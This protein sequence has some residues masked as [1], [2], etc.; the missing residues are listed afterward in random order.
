MATASPVARYALRELL[1]VF[2]PLTPL[3]PYRDA[4]LNVWRTLG[5]YSAKSV[6][7]KAFVLEVS[8]REYAAAVFA[9]AQHL[10]NQVLE[11]R[12]QLF[13]AIA[14]DTEPS[15]T[16]LAVTLYYMGLYAAMSWTRVTNVA[17]VYL[18]REA[19]AQLCG[20]STGHPGAGAFTMTLKVPA[21][22]HQR[23]ELHVSKS[24]SHFHEAVWLHST[25]EARAAL[26]WVSKAAQSRNASSDEFLTIRA[27]SSICNP[28]FDGRPTWPSRL[29]NALNYRPGFS[30][31][32]V[33][34]NNLLRVKSRLAKRGLAELSDVV[35]YC[36]AARRRIGS[37]A[38]PADAANDAVDL[39][40]GITL[41]FEQF[42]QEALVET[43]AIQG[44]TSSA[45][46]QRATYRRAN[47]GDKATYFLAT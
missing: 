43:C 25:A 4:N 11:H 14:G 19:V 17:V 37:A 45:E 18:D 7:N 46:R 29:R 5:S 47:C 24:V 12:A 40:L 9:D 2:P 10:L 30:Y 31:R 44:L 32:S 21:T 16:W 6:G 1:Q 22:G 8:H 27:L 33:V 23:P 39:L 41:L 3:E 13:Q 35:T 36:E 34:R 15:P 28:L 26:D 42:A 38:H 20:T